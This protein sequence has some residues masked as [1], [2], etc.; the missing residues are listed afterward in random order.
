[1]L[2]GALLAF[3]VHR[4]AG[5]KP[6][7]PLLARNVCVALLASKG[8]AGF[9]RTRERAS[10][11]GGGFIWAPEGASKGDA[12]FKVAP[13]RP[14]SGVTGFAG[15][16]LVCSCLLEKSINLVPS[17]SWAGLVECP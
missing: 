11:G 3:L 9:M 7:S 17:S 16:P 15:P 12:G 5:L 14:S 6:L 13:G 8:V 2:P 10:K 1:M 4:A